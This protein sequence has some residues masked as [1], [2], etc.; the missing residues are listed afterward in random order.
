MERL[1]IGDR[2]PPR[3]NQSAPQIRNPNFRRNPPQI[4]RREPKN[5]REQRGHDQQIRPPLQE[6]YVDDGEEIIEEL[7]DIHINLMGVN[8]NDSIFLTQEE[9]ELFLLSQIEV[10]VK[11][12]NI[13]TSRM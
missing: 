11:R 4:R 7:D 5:Q 13:K 12:Q 3:E 9:R 1:E 10:D 6:N 2:N 8:V